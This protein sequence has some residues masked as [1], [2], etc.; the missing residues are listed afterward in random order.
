MKTL[1]TILLALICLF[2]SCTQQSPKVPAAPPAD[3]TRT[4]ATPTVKPSDTVAQVKVKVKVKNKDN[5]DELYARS[6]RSCPVVVKKCYL[7]TDI[8]GSRAIV[9]TMQNNAP[10]KMSAVKVVW[11]VF[12]RSG[13]TLGIA[14]GMAKKALARGRTASYSW[15]VNMHSSAR[16]KAFIY[17]IRYQ[18][19][20][21][22]KVE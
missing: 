11:T 13:K 12:N 16:A 4:A 10:K 15:A 9:V 2:Y 20:S 22:W 14:N 19:G 7:V 17:S 8:N 3:S 1:N 18:D 21:V 5:T 6:R